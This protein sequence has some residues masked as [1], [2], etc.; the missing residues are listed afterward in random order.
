MWTWCLGTWFSGGLC[1]IRLTVGLDDLK[2]LLQS[3]RFYD[4]RIPCLPEPLGL[5]LGIVHT[6]LGSG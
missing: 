2:G 3:K 6:P 5:T 1:S 4:S